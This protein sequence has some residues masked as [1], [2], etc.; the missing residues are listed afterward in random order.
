[1][2]AIG[3]HSVLVPVS[4]Q[5]HQIEWLYWFIFWICLAV[6]LLV[7]AAL[8]R[9][10]ARTYT[11]SHT[12]LPIFEDE[13]GDRSATWAISAAVAVTTI[14][15]F[16][17]LCLSVLTSRKVDAVQAQNGVTIQVIGHQWWWE[18]IYP[19]DEADLTL[20]TA[21]EIHVP[22]GETIAILT[23]SADVIHSFWAPSV[24]GKRD[25]LPGYSSAFT[26]EIDKAGT[27][28]GECA[29]FCGMQHAHMGFAIVA[30]PAEQFAAW[31]KQQL[32]AA[33]DPANAEQARGRDVFLSHP[34]VLCHTIR[35]TSAG[36]RVGP[37]LTHIASRNMIAAETL[38]NNAGNLAGWILD[39]QQ[40]KPGNHMA[41]SALAP[42]DLDALIAYLG[43][44]N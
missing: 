27:Y 32:R 24:T 31:E 14:I 38:P 7:M 34:C 39:P 2:I 12:P 22:L 15:L 4:P 35:G 10:A 1:V 21:N 19:N 41:P 8:A 40:I 26:F 44:L 42:D 11:P 20:T 13:E 29:E 37:D 9:G 28:P 23:N 36:S 16:T 25:L 18:V 43:S 30:E 17:V 33:G 3:S 6:F 5:G